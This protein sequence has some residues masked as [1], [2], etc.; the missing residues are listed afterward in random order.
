[1]DK[2]SIIWKHVG[3]ET[4]DSKKA[5]C[6]HYVTYWVNLNGSTTNCIVHLR[7]HHS[8][9]L[10][11]REKEAMFGQCSGR[12][13]G[14]GSGSGRGAQSRP[15]SAIPNTMFAFED[16]EPNIV[17]ELDSEVDL[18]QKLDSEVKQFRNI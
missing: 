16:D 1:M 18:K 4:L 14:S 7:N 8:D 3:S 15:L 11:E 10:T 17:I 9:L 13:S 12:G 6:K 5:K 2:T